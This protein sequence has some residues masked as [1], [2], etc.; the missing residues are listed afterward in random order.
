MD[1]FLE[2]ACGK[3]VVATEG[4]AGTEVACTCG[5]LVAVPTLGELRRSRGMSDPRALSEETEDLYGG[6]AQAGAMVVYTL[7][8]V[9]VCALAFFVAIVTFSAG[10][11]VPTLGVVLLY[12][13]QLWLFTLIYPGNPLAGLIVLFVPLVGSVMA[14]QFLIDH[15][16]IARWPLFVQVAGFFLWLTV[17][18][19]SR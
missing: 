12:G 16:S 15:W 1:F 2:C 3:Q 9:G 8:V 11:V 14:I 18:V 7:V 5:R 6:S 13:S 19:T 10:G 4:M 17:F